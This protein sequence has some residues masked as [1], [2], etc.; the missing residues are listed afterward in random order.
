MRPPKRRCSISSSNIH[1]SN[2]AN[3]N[4]VENGQPR[5]K[6]PRKSADDAN[7]KLT[8]SAATTNGAA[9]SKVS[10]QCINTDNLYF[11]IRKFI[12]RHHQPNPMRQIRLPR[13][14]TKKRALCPGGKA[15]VIVTAN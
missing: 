13:H 1:T 4:C 2:G 15:R 5:K 11:L 7:K 9:N 8:R 12:F 6:V 14:Q 10:Y 3:H